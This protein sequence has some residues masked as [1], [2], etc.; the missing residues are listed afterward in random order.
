MNDENI[1]KLLRDRDKEKFIQRVKNAEIENFTFHFENSY[2]EVKIILNSYNKFLIG[3]ADAGVDTLGITY[4]YDELC[5]N[6][7]KHCKIEIEKIDFQLLFMDEKV[8]KSY[9][10]REVARNPDVQLNLEKFENYIEQKIPEWHK[11]RVKQ[12]I[13]KEKLK[14]NRAIIVSV[15]NDM[16]A[17]RERTN[18]IVQQKVHE[19]SQMIYSVENLEKITNYQLRGY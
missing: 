4:S 18:P 5:K 15:V 13:I 16:L 7:L 9:V 19:F 11:Q 3:L 10:E 8:V 6:I 12:F 1:E 17:E 14:F 2:E